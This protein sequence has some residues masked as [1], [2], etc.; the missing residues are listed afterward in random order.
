MNYS[1]CKYYTRNW[2]T[3]FHTP[4][5][6]N[7]NGKNFYLFICLIVRYYLIVN[8]IGF[9]FVSNV[10]LRMNWRGSYFIV[11]RV[12]VIAWICLPLNLELFS[13]LVL[14][15]RIVPW[16]VSLLS[17]L[18]LHS[19]FSTGS[20][21]FCLRCS[22]VCFFFSFVHMVLLLLCAEG[23][24]FICNSLL[25]IISFVHFTL[26]NFELFLSL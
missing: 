9:L 8:H 5:I 6:S 2:E 21:L 17:Q 23:L 19:N 18:S 10:T 15:L 7:V 26:F 1:A 12:C 14:L 13:V 25:K 4:K 11:I 16:V 24:H 3:D 20:S 22:D